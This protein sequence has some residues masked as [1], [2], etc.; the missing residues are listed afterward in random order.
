VGE[1]RVEHGRREE[2]GQG[3]GEGSASIL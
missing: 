3:E 1:R 2:L